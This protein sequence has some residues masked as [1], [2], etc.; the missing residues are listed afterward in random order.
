MAETHNA[1]LLYQF[2]SRMRVGAEVLV[3]VAPNM[4]VDVWD[5]LGPPGCADQVSVMSRR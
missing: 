2:R 5:L 3:D 1:E 4:L